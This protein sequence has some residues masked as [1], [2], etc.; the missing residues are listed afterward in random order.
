MLIE[1]T[2]LERVLIETVNVRISH[3]DP[4]TLRNFRIDLIPIKLGSFDL[5]VCMDWL[6]KNRTEICCVEKIVIISSP[7]GGVLE[8][9]G[10]KPKSNT[11]VVSYMKM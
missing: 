1:K 6:S 9:H 8:V 2:T 11:K 7:E 4:I 5:V 10:E 3:S